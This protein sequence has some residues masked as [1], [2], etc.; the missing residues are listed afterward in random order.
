M[1]YSEPRSVHDSPVL[2]ALIARMGAHAGPMLST[3]AGWDE[4]IA[5][6]NGR[7]S[8]LDPDYKVD[9]VKEKFGGL[10]YYYSPSIDDPEVHKAMSAIVGWSAGHTQ[11]RPSRSLNQRCSSRW[12]NRRCAPARATSMSKS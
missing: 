8:E 4:I 7:L 9:Q 11:P 5:E 12:R 3:D 10:R 1:I 2:A 6:A